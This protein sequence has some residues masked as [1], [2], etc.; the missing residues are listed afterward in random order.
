VKGVVEKVVKGVVEKAV[1]EGV[2][3]E[4]VSQQRVEEKKG[5]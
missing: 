4:E 2:E 1:K 3:Q 5:V